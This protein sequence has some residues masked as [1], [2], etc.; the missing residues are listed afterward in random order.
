MDP[1][2]SKTQ[3]YL[4]IAKQ[5]G[6]RSTC[7]RNRGGAIIVNGDQIIATGYIGAPRKTKDCFERGECLRDKLQI[8]HGKQYEMCRSAHAEQNAIINAARSGVSLYGADM[9]ISFDNPKDGSPRD[10]FPCFICKK[11]IINCGINRVI[12][13]NSK[14]EEVVFKV[15]DWVKDWQEKDI[16]DDH[17]QFGTDLNK[18]E[19]L[20][21]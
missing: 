13:T 12:C 10:S 18:K 5:I 20:T 6:L 14:N 21:G 4:T 1:R 7:F 19:G 8:P 17:F 9:Y 3:Y 11:L 16:I 2:P 15:E